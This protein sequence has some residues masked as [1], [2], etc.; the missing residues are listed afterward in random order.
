MTRRR[1]YLLGIATFLLL[2]TGAVAR[3]WMQP[4]G[5]PLEV[6]AGRIKVG[7]TL[8]EAETI[9]GRKADDRRILLVSFSV[10]GGDALIW[11]NERGSLWL[12][13]SPGPSGE[14]VITWCGDWEP[15]LT[16]DPPPT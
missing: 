16:P 7:M 14:D 11:S 1:L 13:V 2:L 9:I 8:A 6:A 15:K 12:V 3:V 4:W 10:S 5:V